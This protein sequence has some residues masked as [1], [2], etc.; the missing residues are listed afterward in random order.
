MRWVGAVTVRGALLGLLWWVFTE[1]DS[2]GWYYG[3]VACA[4]AL[5]LSLRLSPP[6]A[7]G[8]HL[9][10]RAG[11]TVRLVLWFLV[12]SV[13]GGIDVSR[14]I[15]ARR[16]DVHPEVQRHP[17]R[18]EPGHQ[19][20]V[21]LAMVSLMPGTLMVSMAEDTALIHVLDARI[22]VAENWDAL[23]RRIAAAAGTSL[24]GED[25][26]REDGPP[27]PTAQPGG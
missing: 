6:A 5:V 7:P 14:R 26:P 3:V 13:L 23:Q 17:L 22:P 12:H 1:G 24:L 21:A 9:L 25:R 11:H 2:P 4:A 15:L 10:S 20:Q 27:A 8:G 19:R 18:L 16:V